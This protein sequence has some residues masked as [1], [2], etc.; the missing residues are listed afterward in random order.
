MPNGYFD[1]GIEETLCHMPMSMK[2][3]IIRDVT[4]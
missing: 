3:V 2:T 1:Y 4:V